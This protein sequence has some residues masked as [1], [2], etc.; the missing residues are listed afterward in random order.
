MIIEPVANNHVVLTTNKGIIISVSDD[1]DYVSIQRKISVHHS[2]TKIKG[3][4]VDYAKHFSDEDEP[5][6]DCDAVKVT[7]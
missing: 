2:P 6:F 1:G 4:L 7:Q 5:T 3:V